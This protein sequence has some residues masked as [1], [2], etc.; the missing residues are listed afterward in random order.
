MTEVL[1]PC[2]LEGI[3]QEA[4]CPLK[5]GAI[6]R[7]YASEDDLKEMA[8][9]DKKIDDWHN[10]QEYSKESKLSMGRR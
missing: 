9:T 10:W 2:A 6:C 4:V 7:C 5:I 3:C 8:E 1:A